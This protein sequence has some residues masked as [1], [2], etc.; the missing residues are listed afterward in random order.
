MLKSMTWWTRATVAT[1]VLLHAPSCMVRGLI[2]SNESATSGAEDVGEEGV[3]TG[4]ESGAGESDSLGD[5]EDT[6]ATQDGLST[7]SST[8]PA[9][10]NETTLGSP[11]YDVNPTVDPSLCVPPA[12]PSCDE[13]ETTTWYEAM[14]MGCGSPKTWSFGN[15]QDTGSLRIHEGRLG[16]ETSPFSPREGSRMVV[17]STGRAA[18]V[19]M[20]PEQLR[21][22]H[23]DECDDARFC[24]SSDL[25][26]ERRETLP[27][28]LQ[29]RGVDPQTDCSEDPSLVGQGDCSNSLEEQWAL[30][31][32]VYDYAE[33]RLRTVVPAYTHAV[34]FDF[35]FFSSE[36]PLYTEHSDFSPYNDMYIAWLE[37]ELWTG[38][39][40]FDNGMNPITVHS[41]FLDYRSASED[42]PECEA[43][44][45]EGFAMQHHAGTRWLTTNAPVTTGE[46]IDLVFALF[47]LTDAEF[48]SVVLLDNF[49]WA[50]SDGPPV[51]WA[52]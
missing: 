25:G 33:L 42:C 20:T 4:Q 38:N 10:S 14:G 2:G 1:V 34:Q 23:P 47:D 39:V 30:G 32:G 28:P 9:D 12:M 27:P 36:Y 48:D 35:A 3:S 26:G 40:S 6:A 21:A 13:S 5:D 24:P 52:E 50:C 8:E 45:L 11:L 51:T 29:P 43:P 22:L 15:I 31:D 7:S 49:S 17:L 46:T 41:V 16:G 37:S 44:E 18:E 19:A